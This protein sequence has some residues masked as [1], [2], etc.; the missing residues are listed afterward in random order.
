[1][2]VICQL[3]QSSFNNLI[4]SSHLKTVHQTTSAKYKQDFGD[5]SLAS[6]EYRARRSEQNKGENNPNFGNKMSQTSKEVISQKNTGRIPVNKGV[7]VTDPVILDKIHKAVDKR[8]QRYK[9]QG[10][11]PRT[12]STV[13]EQ[14]RNKIGQGVNAYAQQN[15]DLVKQRAAKAQQTL[16]DRGYLFGSGMRG[17]KHTPASLE[18][19]KKAREIANLQK[20]VQSLDKLHQAV[21]SSGLEFIKLEA[22]VVTIKCDSCDNQFNLTRQYFTPSKLRSDMCPLCRPAKVKSDAELELLSYVREILPNQLIVSG[23]R[24]QI[25]PLELDI[26]IPHKRLAIEYCG[27]YWH[28]EL[29]GKH[30]MYH[31]HKMQNC[32]SQGIRLITIFEDEWILN[33][34]LVRSRLAVILGRAIHK[35]HAR[36]CM[37]KQIDCALAREFCRIN[38]IQGAGSASAAIGLYYEHML[39]SVATFSKPNISKGAKKSQ[40]NHWE[41]N[42]LCSLADHVVRGAANKLFAH[43][44]KIYNPDQVITYCDLRWNTGDVYSHMGFI[45][46]SVGFP[47]YWYIQLPQIKRMHRFGLRKTT[48]DDPNLT[49]W[50]NRK[51][52]GFNRIW[53]CGH[54]KW[55][56]KNKNAE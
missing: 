4:S 41:L 21:Q 55:I 34:N 36:K 30:K 31:K 8:E 25:S 33:P 51:L 3:C 24:N 7:K 52:Q 48:Q 56:W 54:S 28:S 50:E 23:D 37:V 44:V 12:G 43:F 10:I 45:Q 5:D 16:R 42:R 15:P 39:V 29:Q 27:L 53:D 32:E 46:H 9:E 22:N 11:H 17:K 20:S 26:Y 19:M 13:N 47:N 38:H 1:M 49:E 35:L 18:A 40:A 14:T 2:P 6:A